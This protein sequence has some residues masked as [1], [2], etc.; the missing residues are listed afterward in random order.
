MNI[1]K[2]VISLLLTFFLIY[3][4]SVVILFISYRDNEKWIQILNP[5]FQLETWL[6]VFGW[7]LGNYGYFLMGLLALLIY[8]GVFGILNK[9]YFKK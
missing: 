3:L 5:I 1:K 4:I 8:L 7:S 2:I 9:Y 6:F